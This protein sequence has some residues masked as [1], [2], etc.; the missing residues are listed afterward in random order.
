MDSKKEHMPFTR[1]DGSCAF[2]AE[3]ENAESE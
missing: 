2:E 1:G 3:R